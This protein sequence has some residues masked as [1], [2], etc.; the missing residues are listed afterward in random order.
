M[1]RSTRIL[2]TAF[3][4]FQGRS[5]NGSATL[6]RWLRSRRTPDQFVSSILPVDWVEA[7]RRLRQLLSRYSPTAVLSLGEGQPGRVSW[8]C[9]AVN[10]QSGTDE[11]GRTKSPSAI[12]TGYK[13]IL[14]SAIPH[15]H[16]QVFSSLPHSCRFELSN[17]AGTFLCNRI[18]WE[19]LQETS[20]RA[21]FLHLPPQDPIPDSN[22]T[23]SIGTFLL[24]LLAML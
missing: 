1:A 3:R 11:L 22:Y 15:P 12:Q 7:P 8:E 5:S 21:C 13:T 24:D 2:I 17:D 14:N 23:K 4:P 20:G 6:L 10:F 9:Q 18:F 19:A 16:D